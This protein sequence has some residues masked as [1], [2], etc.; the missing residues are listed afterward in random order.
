MT[1]KLRIYIYIEKAIY[2][3]E[4]VRGILFSFFGANMDQPTCENRSFGFQGTICFR[5]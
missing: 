2:T 5:I 3:V 4:S 1:K